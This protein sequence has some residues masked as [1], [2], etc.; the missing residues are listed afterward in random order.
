MTILPFSKKLL[1][2]V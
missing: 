1:L 2:L